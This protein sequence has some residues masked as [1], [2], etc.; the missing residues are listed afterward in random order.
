MSNHSPIPNLPIEG[1]ANE[2]LGPTRVAWWVYGDGAG[3][4]PR[5]RFTD[6]TGQSFQA[7]GQKITWK[8]WRYI[9][10]ALRPSDSEP[11]FHWGAAN[12]GV[13]HYPLKW[14]S[15]FL[16]DNPAKTAVEGE[17]Y[18]SAPTLLY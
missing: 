12:D 6:A 7:D 1:E 15:M 8:G 16:L 13:V 14:D 3:C 10:F 18:L 5:I 4:T 9:T 2:N 11:L 17:I